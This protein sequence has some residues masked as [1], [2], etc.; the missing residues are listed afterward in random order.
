MMTP[1]APTEDEKKQKP[2]AEQKAINISLSGRLGQYLFDLSLKGRIISTPGFD[3]PP[4]TNIAA[5]TDAHEEDYESLWYKM[6]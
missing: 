4:D 5:M 1:A 6:A 3:P 2:L